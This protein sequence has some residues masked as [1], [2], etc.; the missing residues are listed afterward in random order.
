[1]TIPLRLG[2]EQDYAN[3]AA[4]GARAYVLRSGGCGKLGGYGDCR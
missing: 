3:G 4:R 2:E 1:M